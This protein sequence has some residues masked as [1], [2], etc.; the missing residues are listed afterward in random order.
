MKRMMVRA[1]PGEKAR[2][3]ASAVGQDLQEWS[4][5]R[6]G[7]EGVRARL[8]VAVVHGGDGDDD[9]RGDVREQPA[10]LRARVV[11]DRAGSVD[12]P[13]LQRPDVS[14]PGRCPASRS[15]QAAAT[16][17]RAWASPRMSSRNW[18]TWSTSCMHSIRKPAVIHAV[19][20]SAPLARH[21]RLRYRLA[22][23]TSFSVTYAD[24]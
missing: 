24:S 17:Y 5:E 7:E 19:C 10:Q 9:A 23:V 21:H 6:G 15:A 1:M 12:A 2:Q 11:G 22:T 14:V 18:P 4:P 3:A 13:G 8:P 20:A 16:P